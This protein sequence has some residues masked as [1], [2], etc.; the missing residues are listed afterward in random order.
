MVAEFSMARGTGSSNR[1]FKLNVTVMA[2]NDA[3][4]TAGTIAITLKSTTRRMCSLDAVAPLRRSDQRRETRQM[5]IGV[6]VAT[7]RRFSSKRL[8]CIIKVW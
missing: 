4:K 8:M 6:I 1:E 5:M 7:I 2:E 3:T